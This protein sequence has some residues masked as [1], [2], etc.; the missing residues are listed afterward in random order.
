[1]FV[2]NIAM[3]SPSHPI[4]FLD[5]S[6]RCLSS[7]YTY[8]VVNNIPQH[9]CCSKDFICECE[10]MERGWKKKTSR[11]CIFILCSSLK[12]LLPF[13]PSFRALRRS[14]VST[15]L[16]CCS[17]QE[18]ITAM[19]IICNLRLNHVFYIVIRVGTA[20]KFNLKNVP[21]VVEFDHGLLYL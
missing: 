5:S 11:S 19:D 9:V 17:I 18:Y 4:I 15:I 12:C 6:W 13:P 2:W 3:R 1:M 16:F 21:N 20:F 8:S 7:K 10:R 14:T